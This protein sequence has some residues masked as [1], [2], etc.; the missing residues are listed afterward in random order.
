MNQSGATHHELDAAHQR[1]LPLRVGSPAENGESHVAIMDYLN[2][3]VLRSLEVPGEIS[4]AADN[5]A[6]RVVRAVNSFNRL[7]QA[8]GLALPTS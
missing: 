1:S 8:C 6:H 2:R 4:E 7:V 5:R 3:E